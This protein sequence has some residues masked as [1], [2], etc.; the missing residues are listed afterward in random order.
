[1]VGN[2]KIFSFKCWIIN[3]TQSW[4]CFQFKLE[5]SERSWEE[6]II[7]VSLILIRSWNF[8]ILFR[9]SLRRKNVSEPKFNQNFSNK[10]KW[11]DPQTARNTFCMRDILIQNPSKPNP[12]RN[13]LQILINYIQPSHIN[14]FRKWSPLTC[15]A[16]LS[17]SCNHRK[18]SIL[19]RLVRG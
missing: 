13:Q 12:K 16:V 3:N 9:S 1:M 15:R 2:I 18:R 8:N 6:I 7:Q 4:I 11:P 10:K 5:R 17:P 14:G 19:L